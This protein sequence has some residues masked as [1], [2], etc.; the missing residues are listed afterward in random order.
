MKRIVL[1]SGNPGKVREL[2]GLLKETGIQVIPQSEYCVP[3]AEET[4]LSFIENAILKARHACRH[5][6][7][8]ALA[9]DSGLEVDFLDGEPGIYSARYAG[10]HG[11]DVANNDRLLGELDGVPEAERTARFRCVIA[12]L[13][14]AEDPMPLVV[15]G[16]WEGRILTQ[17]RG[18]GGFGYDPLFFDRE[19]GR[20]A[21]ELDA[22]TKNRHSHRG[23]ALQALLAALRAEPARLSG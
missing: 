1:A 14:H 5:T 21:A 7:L 17:P 15:S 6:D 4:G 16:T 10:S 22:R 8:P 23:R 18:D 2:Q 9:D 11:D 19:L 13:R 3:D 12:L 20:S